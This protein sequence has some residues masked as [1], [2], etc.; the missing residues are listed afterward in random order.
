VL[1]D[2]V[3]QESILKLCDLA[4]LQFVKIT[5]YTRIDNSH[6]FFNS[7]GSCKQTNHQINDLNAILP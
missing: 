4:G 7:H 5:P 6:L 1:A 3:R 2:N